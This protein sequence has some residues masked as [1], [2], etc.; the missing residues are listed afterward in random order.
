MSYTLGQPV[1]NLGSY[2]KL[3]YPV[4]VDGG[5]YY[6][7]W[8]RSGDGTSADVGS[9]NNGKDAVTYDILLGLF[10]YT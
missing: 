3:I 9:L 1:I 5:R 7:Y 2:G 8:D 6:Y 10:R 4:Q